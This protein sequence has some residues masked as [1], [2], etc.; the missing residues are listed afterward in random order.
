MQVNR[1]SLSSQEELKRAINFNANSNEALFSDN[2]NGTQ[3]DFS[4][5]NIEDLNIS[6]DQIRVLLGSF[7]DDI[8]RI[9]GAQYVPSAQNQQQTESESSKDSAESGQNQTSGFLA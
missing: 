1:L 8:I 9:F 5:M 2:A 7:T 3:V 6:E 4:E